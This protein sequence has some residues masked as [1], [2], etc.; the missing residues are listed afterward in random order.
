[1]GRRKKRMHNLLDINTHHIIYTIIFLLNY[2]LKYLRCCVFSREMLHHILP[3]FPFCIL[4][5]ICYYQEQDCSCSG[6]SI[7]KARSRSRSLPMP[8]SSPLLLCLFYSFVIDTTS[9]V[10]V[11]IMHSSCFELCISLYLRIV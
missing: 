1:M 6:Y 2:L 7:C 3:K 4:F 9:H 11:S 5:L 10:D 8:M